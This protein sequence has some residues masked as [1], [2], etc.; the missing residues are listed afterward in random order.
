MYVLIED[1]DLIE[2]YILL[3]I[4]SAFIYIYKKRIW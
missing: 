2:K 3:R 1:D 4:N